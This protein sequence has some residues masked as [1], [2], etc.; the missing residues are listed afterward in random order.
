[1]VGLDAGVCVCVCVL[2]VL[3]DIV[4]FVGRRHEWCNLRKPVA[5]GD[6]ERTPLLRRVFGVLCRKGVAYLVLRSVAPR[7]QKVQAY[8]VWEDGLQN[9]VGG[10]DLLW[11]PSFMEARTY[12]YVP[13][14]SPLA[15]WMVYNDAGAGGRRGWLISSSL[16][17]PSVYVTAS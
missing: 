10:V 9:I 14:S 6:R 16:G 8:P 13:A 12:A 5:S 7:H 17:L 15:G 4:D 2:L 11:D 3:L 1:M